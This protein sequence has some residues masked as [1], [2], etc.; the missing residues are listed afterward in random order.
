LFLDKL[1]TETTA[2]KERG[3]GERWGKEER[4]KIERRSYMHVNA[5]T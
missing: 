1:L 4:R 2:E 5:G 3:R